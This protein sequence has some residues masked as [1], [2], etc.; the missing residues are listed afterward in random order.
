MDFKTHFR[1]TFFGNIEPRGEG[2]LEM[3][4]GVEEG[5]MPL[6]TEE[7]GSMSLSRQEEE[8]LPADT[9]NRQEKEVLLAG[10]ESREEGMT[11]FEMYLQENVAIL[12]TVLQ[13]V[14]SLEEKVTSLEEKI[15][16][17]EEKTTTHFKTALQKATSLEKKVTMFSQTSLEDP[18][19]TILQETTDTPWNENG[20]KQFSNTLFCSREMNLQEGTNTKVLPDTDIQY[21]S[22]DTKVLPDTD[23]QYSSTDTKNLPDPRSTTLKRRGFKD[24]FKCNKKKCPKKMNS[25]KEVL[26]GISHKKTNP[27]S[28]TLNNG[29]RLK[30]FFKKYFKG[31]KKEDT[32]GGQEEELPADTE[33]RE[34]EEELPADTDCRQE[35]EQLPADTDCRQEEE[36]LPADTDCRQEEEVVLADTD[37]RQEKEE[38]P[39][40]TGSRQEEVLPADSDSRGGQCLLKRTLSF[41]SIS[42]FLSS[43]FLC[44]RKGEGRTTTKAN[45]TVTT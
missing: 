8:E 30:Q 5:S 37:C 32:D 43:P 33:S 31:K 40:G 11:L 15:T 39:A 6:R 28:T 27:D 22:T 21:S 36:E 24:F 42:I 17:L 9:D 34:E 23:I 2:L 29:S 26:S 38:L 3:E 20:G 1:K 19:T 16:S 4:V 12:K 14:T 25:G 44:C 45:P 35:E 18:S 13:K 7:K 41:H 10:T